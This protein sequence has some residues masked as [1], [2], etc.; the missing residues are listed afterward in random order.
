MLF[1][2]FGSSVSRLLEQSK[3]VLFGRSGSSVS[4]LLE[5]YNFV[6]FE[7]SGRRM[8]RLLEQFKYINL[9][10]IFLMESSRMLSLFTTNPVIHR[11][12][13]TRLKYRHTSRISVSSDQK[14]TNVKMYCA[15]SFG[16]TSMLYLSKLIQF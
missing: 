7:R 8:S 6:L 13:T 5:Q 14:P 9:S 11:H 16:R 12:D 1:G 3:Y 4:W 2:S 10:V 15:T